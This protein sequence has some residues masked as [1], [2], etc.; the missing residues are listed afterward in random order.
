MLSELRDVA[1]TLLQLATGERNLEMDPTLAPIVDQLARVID[2]EKQTDPFQR[3]PEFVLKMLPFLRAIADYFG[4][5]LRGWENVPLR[6]PVIFVGNHSGGTMTVD[7]IP[8]I[9]RWVE[10]R[11]PD[12]P[13]CS[14]AYDLLFAYPMIGDWLRRMGNL[15][16]SHANGRFALDKG[17]SVIV[18]PGGDYEVFRPWRERNRIDFGGRTGFVELAIRAGVRVVPMTIHGAHESTLV[19]TRGHRIAR[20]MGLD[21]LRIKVFPVI[22][23]VP[24]GLMPAF[25]PSFPLPAKITVSLGEPLDW[26]H[27]SPEESDDPEV[28]QA[29]YDEITGVMQ[30]TLTRLAAERPYPLLSRMADL[31]PGR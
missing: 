5:E 27:Y 17:A 6:E 2:E 16:A 10:E 30:E 4:A 22:W 28:L 12:V 9:V 15:P 31:L 25:V 26:R 29:C 3:D 7:P 14:L 13:I 11:G 24:F 8:L 18:F 20:T 19:L 1:A 21:R 23:N